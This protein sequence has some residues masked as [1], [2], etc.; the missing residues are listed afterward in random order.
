MGHLHGVP[1][2]LAAPRSEPCAGQLHAVPTVRRRIAYALFPRCAVLARVS[3][4]LF[5]RCAGGSATLCF[6]VAQ[7]GQLCAVPMLR[8]IG[9][10]A[11]AAA[12]P[13]AW[14]SCALF[15]AGS[16][17]LGLS[18][19]RVSHT[20]FPRCAGGSATRC[21]HIAQSLRGSATRCSHVAQAGLL[22]SAHVAQA[23]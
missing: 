8:R 7:A 19:A 9:T 21:S 4:T 2:W 11:P 15:P 13:S 12:L 1:C 23:G 14:V 10:S 20:L 5:Q 16:L 6:P 3:Y 18:P 17:H 22:H